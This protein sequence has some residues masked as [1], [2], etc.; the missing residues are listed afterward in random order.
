MSY[1]EFENQSM[2]HS[3]D[4]LCSLVHELNIYGPPLLDFWNLGDSDYYVCRWTS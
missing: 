2:E 3:D 4:V 1:M